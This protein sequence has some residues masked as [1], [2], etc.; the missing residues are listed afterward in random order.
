MSAP[1]IHLICGSTGAGK[2]IYSCELSARLGAVH[3]SIDEWMAVLFWMDNPAPKDPAWALERIDRCMT[4]IWATARQVAARGT[5]CILDFGFGSKALRTRFTS[6]AKAEGFPLQ[7]HFLDVPAE[8]RWRRVQSRNAAGSGQ[9]AFA[10]TREMFDYVESTFEPPG[11][12]E[13]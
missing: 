13:L 7:L 2:T 12:D 11:A 9:L 1:L 10:I 3:F 6:L 4:Q 8:E 5:P